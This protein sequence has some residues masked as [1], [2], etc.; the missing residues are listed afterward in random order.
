VQQTECL[1]NNLVGAGEYRCR[2]LETDGLGSFEVDHQLVFGRPLHRQVGW[3]LTAQNSIHIACG[4]PI[5][6]DPIRP[7]GD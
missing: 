2:H 3:F 6:I 5:L 4:L 1:F 7:I